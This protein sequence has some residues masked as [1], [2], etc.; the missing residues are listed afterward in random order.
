M[1]FERKREIM[2][3]LLLFVQKERFIMYFG[4]DKT[5]G[6]R[7][8]FVK[9]LKFIIVQHQPLENRLCLLEIC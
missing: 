2:D 9:C 5:K 1:Q 7:K 6:K 3:N 4:L 8:K